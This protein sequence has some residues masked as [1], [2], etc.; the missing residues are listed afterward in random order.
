MTEDSRKWSVDDCRED[1]RAT[2]NFRVCE[3]ILVVADVGGYTDMASEERNARLIASAP[4]LYEMLRRIAS[5]DRLLD[6]LWDMRADRLLK[7]SVNELLKK[8][9]GEEK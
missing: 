8:A 2:C 3:G 7:E 1:K 9:G 5:Q 6:G 4:E